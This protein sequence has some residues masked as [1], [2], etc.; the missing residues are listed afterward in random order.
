MWNPQILLIPYDRNESFPYHSFKCW[1]PPPLNPPPM[2]DEE[3]EEAITRCVSHPPLCK[4]GYCSDESIDFIFMTLA[5]N[6]FCRI[7]GEDVISMNL[8]MVLGT[9]GRTT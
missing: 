6:V 2:K 4:C 7:V 8:F 1:V 3:K 9:I 5:Y